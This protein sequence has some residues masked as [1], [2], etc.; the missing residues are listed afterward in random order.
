[1]WLQNTETKSILWGVE[2][3]GKKVLCY[4]SRKK[5]WHINLD[6]V[7]NDLLAFLNS[8]NHFPWKNK[9]QQCK[10]TRQTFILSFIK[11][12]LPFNSKS[13]GE[14]EEL[15]RKGYGRHLDVWEHPS[16]ITFKEVPQGLR[17]SQCI[18]LRGTLKSAS[19]W[20]APFKQYKRLQG[21]EDPIVLS[22]ETTF[23]VSEV[24][25][26][27]KLFKNISS[28]V[29]D[30][31]LIHKEDFQLAPFKNKIRN[32]FANMCIPVFTFFGSTGW[33][34]NR[35]TKKN[36]IL[37]LEISLNLCSLLYGRIV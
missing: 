29:I 31:G 24:E 11:F 12:I 22:R 32:L 35:R 4:H 1:M 3:K 16:S 2:G 27:Y 8:T 5:K 28:Y 21:Y 36:C 19:S 26:L 7:F 23:S 18:I 14:E 20:A 13:S 30:S 17:A 25:V 9:R 33:D 34:R 10:K 6:I 37:S 15:L